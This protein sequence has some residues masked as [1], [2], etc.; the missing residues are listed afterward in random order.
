MMP[1]WWALSLG[2]CF[3]GNGTLIASSANVIVAGLAE[4]ENTHISFLKFLGFGIPVM[5]IS[6]LTAMLYLYIRHFI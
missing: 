1:V 6:V 4:K 2:A 5:I 3:G